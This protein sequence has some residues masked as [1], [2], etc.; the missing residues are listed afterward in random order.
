MDTLH[1]ALIPVKHTH[2]GLEN[3][4]PD[5]PATDRRVC[6]PPRST[7]LNFFF[8]FSSPESTRD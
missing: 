7:A 3:P 5:P 6:P 4:Q 1:W 8:G 2:L